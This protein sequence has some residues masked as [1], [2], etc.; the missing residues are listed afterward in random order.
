MILIL[1]IYYKGNCMFSDKSN[2]YIRYYTYTQEY[3]I[4]YNINNILVYSMKSQ[5]FST[6]FINN[7]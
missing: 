5:Y 2:N 1:C 3:N 7:K 6:L 4:E